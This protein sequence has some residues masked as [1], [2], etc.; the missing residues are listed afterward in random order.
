MRS[1]RIALMSLEPQDAVTDSDTYGQALSDNEGIK[2][3]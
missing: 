1:Y 3:R 2:M